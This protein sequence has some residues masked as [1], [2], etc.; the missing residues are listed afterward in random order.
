MAPDKLSACMQQVR[1]KSNLIDPEGDLDSWIQNEEEPGKLPRAEVPSAEDIE[2]Q[3]EEDFLMPSPRFSTQWLN[4]LQRYGS[5]FQF[6][7]LCARMHA[8]LAVVALTTSCS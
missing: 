3:L 4:K 8:G 2:R 5:P 1:E 6:S 7:L